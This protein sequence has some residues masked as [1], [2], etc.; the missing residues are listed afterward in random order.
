MLF[1]QIMHRL[2]HVPRFVV[3]QN[4]SSLVKDDLTRPNMDWHDAHSKLPRPELAKFIQDPCHNVRATHR[5]CK[6]PL[7]CCHPDPSL[8][9]GC[10][11]SHSSDRKPGVHSTTRTLQ[12]IIM[13]DDGLGLPVFE[14]S[15]HHTPAQ[16]TIYVQ[17]FCP[18][19]F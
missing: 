18:V 4:E 11:T 3:I 13:L 10:Q 15:K 1:V 5:S 8:K 7:V 19:D 17:S 2:K 6:S 9:I 14:Q 16:T 12:E